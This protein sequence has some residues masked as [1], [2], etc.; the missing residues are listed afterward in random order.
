M[1]IIGPFHSSWHLN[2][3]ALDIDSITIIQLNMGSILKF[4]I[5]QQ[6]G[7]FSG[8]INKLK[9]LPLPVLK[10][11]HTSVEL[12]RNEVVKIKL[13]RN[14]FLSHRLIIQTHTKEYTFKIE[15]RNKF[16]HYES[17]INAWNKA[18]KSSA[19]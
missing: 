15:N 18:Y 11:K 10:E 14:K 9:E 19:M 16:V 1:S 4:S 6:M 13:V 7:F 12:S 2:L 3:I 8:H 17:L 5:S